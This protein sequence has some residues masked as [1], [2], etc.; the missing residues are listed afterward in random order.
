MKILFVYSDTKCS[1]TKKC[2]FELSK[3]VGQLADSTII[4]YTQL[5]EKHILE[6]EVIIFQRIG[7][8]ATIITAP[9]R[10][11]LFAFVEKYKDKKIFIYLIDDLVIED[12]EGLP[13]KFMLRCNAVICSTEAMKRHLSDYNKNIH[14]LRTFVDS[15]AVETTK[16]TGLDGF[17][18]MWASS[19]GLSLDLIRVL[20]PQV[21]K[22]MKVEFIC[23]GR[24]T[25]Y[26]SNIEGTTCYPILPFE[27]MIALLKDCQLLLNPM[28]PDRNT[29]IAIT[30]RTHK[31]ID[32]F[33]DCKSEIK[34]ALA[35]ATK[36]A[37]ISSKREA[38]LFAIENN[39]KGL[40]VEDTVESFIEAIK[41]LY[42]D[43]NLRNSIIQ[44]AY[45]D[46]MNHYTLKY[47][48]QCAIEIF[49]S[50]LDGIT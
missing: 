33:L 40:L 2:C 46:V 27:Q 26:L 29:I 20:I 11:K 25:R 37:I 18:I 19:G 4:Y 21:R 34:Y 23:L 49:E 7:A 38:Y 15:E 47:A 12:Q 45:M 35:G 17:N 3:G 10:D 36:T 5:D 13:K 50:C 39:K 30:E 6:H 16:K 48:A 28:V 14:V 22:E 41:K 42:F 31:T 24:N 8:N 32:E 43:T 44:E 1:C 9:Y